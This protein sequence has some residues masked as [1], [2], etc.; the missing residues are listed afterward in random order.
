[1]K[2]E[3]KGRCSGS[4]SPC[5]PLDLT[6]NSSPTGEGLQERGFQIL[7][8]AKSLQERAGGG[9]GQERTDPMKAQTL[10]YSLLLA[11][12]LGAAAAAGQGVDGYGPWRF[13][14]SKA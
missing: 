14:M 13:G 8:M 11:T 1:M 7:K 5:C 4:I 3:G 2:K 6:P 10:F 9:K 12:M